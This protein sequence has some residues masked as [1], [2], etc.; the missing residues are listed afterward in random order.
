MLQQT[1]V[2]TVMNR[3]SSF[4]VKF[5]H[6]EALAKAP[7]EEVLKAWEGLG[8]Y[9]R[10]RHLKAAAEM[11]LD[12]YGGVFP[13]NFEELK[14]I[15]GIGDYTANALISIGMNQRALAI[16]ANIER[17][18]SRYFTFPEEKGPRL[19]KRIAKEFENKKILNQKISFRELNEALMDVGRVLCKARSVSCELCP[20]N[21]TCQAYKSNKA[22]SYPKALTHKKESNH[23]EL[24][25]LRLI[26]KKG[27]K[28][29]VYQ[30]SDQEWLSGQWEFPSFVVKSSD[31]ALKQ[32]PPIPNE[33][34]SLFST[35]LDMVKTGITKYKIS[36]YALIL[37][38]LP[39]T[40][41]VQGDFKSLS[42]IQLSSACK[43]FL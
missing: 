30:K 28:Y 17:V 24:V 12:V 18:L 8:Y 13:E 37:N 2:S 21:E 22:L 20:L 32:Y 31:K 36:N 16:D 43:K 23:E 7:M 15:K 33:L 4:I 3:F 29:L 14:K 1:T 6:I 27:S 11:I 25:L 19:M 5:P 35:N 26:I 41:K 34:S 38:K 9:R 10:A 40:I 39:K 42:E